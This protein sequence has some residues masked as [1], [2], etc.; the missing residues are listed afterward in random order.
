MS[1]QTPP[2]LTR[3]EW[4]AL[5]ALAD[6]SPGRAWPEQPAASRALFRDAFALEARG[7][8]ERVE[9]NNVQY[10]PTAGGI[11]AL[12]ILGIPTARIE[13]LAGRMRLERADARALTAAR[14]AVEGWQSAAKG[15]ADQVRAWLTAWGTFG[16]EMPRE[17]EPELTG[18]PGDAYALHERR[19]ARRNY[20]TALL[21]RVWADL[22]D[23]DRCQVAET[24]AG[25]AESDAGR[26]GVVQGRSWTLAEALGA[27]INSRGRDF[28]AMRALGE[29]LGLDPFAASTRTLRGDPANDAPE[30][31]ET[32]PEYTD[33]EAPT[34][35]EQTND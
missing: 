18:G 35:Q 20:R 3:E 8:V 27:A 19:A 10:V 25:K 23:L 14:K 32:N 12:K 26:E 31:T 2:T 30:Y 16:P 4:A 9:D 28:S 5:L 11:A 22:D 6:T 21:R 15:Y 13:A 17:A 34:E 33:V 1:D 24:A 7:L 29:I